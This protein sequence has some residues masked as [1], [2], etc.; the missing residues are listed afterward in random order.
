M[1]K[2]LIA[3]LMVLCL[4]V[5]MAAAAFAEPTLAGYPI[6]ES[7]KFKDPN[8]KVRTFLPVFASTKADK[9]NRIYKG[10]KI[11]SIFI[12]TDGGTNE[13]LTREKGYQVEGNILIVSAAGKV[14]LEDRLKQ[15]RI[16]GNSTVKYDKKAF[17]LKL[18]N[19]A[20]LF[21]MEEDKTWILLANFIDKSLMRNMIG[22]RLAEQIGL[23]FTPQYQPVD[24]WLNNEYQGCYLLCEK[25]EFGTGRV[26]VEK[27]YLLEVY[28][29]VSTNTDE[30]TFTLPS[31]WGMIIK[32][33]S[34][35][36]PE[37][38]A[39]VKAYFT[40]VDEAL[41]DPKGWSKLKEL[42]D[43]ESLVK[44]Y[45]LDEFLANFDGGVGSQFFVLDTSGEKP[46]AYC[47]P[48]WD[49]D[50]I[51]GITKVMGEPG[52]FYVAKRWEEYSLYQRLWQMSGFRDR[53]R[54]CYRDEFRPLLSKLL[55]WI[56]S[57]S[58][59][60]SASAT[61]NF[62][63]WPIDFGYNKNVQDTGHS[64]KRNVEFI[65]KYIKERRTLFDDKWLP[66]IPK[67]K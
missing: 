27:G 37:D 54:I 21:G 59:L 52:A 63:R 57:E 53:A 15:L 61:M 44:K 56:K 55:T 3:L 50:N 25:V 6:T 30:A 8:H 32:E 36:T 33:P 42:V 65:T 29:D 40:K 13:I 67:G 49:Y 45:I 19:K 22:L 1:S 4:T 24:L 31:G 26:D 39:Y 18:E 66:R 46:M 41:S 2:R 51:L 9:T 14:L 38:V 48:V 28:Q 43:G 17:Q 10:S 12:A 64:F 34:N 62:Y 16:R 11:P 47:G 60:L 7:K 35:Y 5:G 58:E 23:P 20:S